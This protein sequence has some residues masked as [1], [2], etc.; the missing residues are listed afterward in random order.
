MLLQN[1]KIA[2]RV[3]TRHKGYALINLAGITVG[4][5][6]CLLIGLYIQHELSYDRYH[7]NHKNIYRLANK[8]DGASF[9]NGIAKIS[10]PWGPGLAKNFPEVESYCRFVF[11]GESL[12]KYG[13]KQSYEESGFYADSTVLK[14]FSWKLIKGDPKT[15]MEAPNNM[16]ISETF[17]KKYFGNE[18]P[19]GKTFTVGSDNDLYK[20]TGLIK[21]VPSNSHFRFDF[22]ATLSSYHHPDMDKWN[23]WNQFYT[24]LL[25]K[26]GVS[27]K[28]IEQKAHPFIDQHLDSAT[29]AVCTPFLQPLAGIHLH[30]D[31]FR[32]IEPN[33]NS[34]YVYIFG[35]LALF[36]ILIACLNFINLS[37]AQAIRRGTE[38]G[39]RKVNGASRISL[40][41]QFLVETILI[42]LVSI[43][44]AITLA[45]ITLPYLNNFLE[46]EIP[47]NWLAG[48]WILMGLL[49]LFVFV[50]LLSGLYPAAVLAS[51]NPAKIIGKRSSGMLS[52]NLLRKSLVVC[53][54]S[55]SI[56]M[57]IAAIV[58]GMQLNY[59][60]NKKLGFNKDQILIIQLRNQETIRRFETIKQELKQVPGVISV[61]ASANRPGGS[62]FGIPFEIE[63]IP[64][65]RLPAMRNLVVDHDFLE[66]YQMEIVSGRG[67]SKEMSTDTGTYLINEEAAR[68]LGLKNTVGTM[69]KMP[70]FNRAPA[71]I[72]GVV[73][74]FHFRSLH[75]KIAPL[76]LFIAPAWFSQV[77]VRINTTNT[78]ETIEGLS[79]KWAAI[80]PGNPFS[81]T[82]FDEG[83]NRLYISETRTAT[84]IRIFS[85]LA[86]FI[87]CL[88][89]L[90]LATHATQQ[91]IK[92]I[93]IRKVLGAKVSGIVYLL[94]IDFLKL[95]IIA[96][97][98]A[99]PIAWWA[100]NDWLKD[101]AYRVTIEWWVFAIAGMSAL[102]I[103][104]LTVGYK[105]ISAAIVNPV[106][107]LRTE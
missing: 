53:Q 44:L 37:T 52:G 71:P 58:T 28:A 18:D 40:M 72:I 57:I 3:L 59:I 86:I 69:M 11:F 39:I 70:A 30:S 23:R 75:E 31:L 48:K 67:F 32:E 84:I 4:V 105:A 85:T 22:L 25:L 66:T 107:S 68:Q 94:S 17:A 60:N 77:S 1:L 19:I 38:V 14:I 95:V 100:M 62:D 55:I 82:F 91:R 73:K 20:V 42:C 56:V 106:K 43:V 97:I 76:F 51:F 7:V 65:D 2:F 104:L 49:I 13:D 36:I 99:F 98:I 35:T 87:A 90:G 15:A 102:L 16:I 96:A 34:N 61:T 74:D 83:F 8:V 47:F 27:V 41:W 26:P 89:L 79:Q 50:S 29:A 5:T 45:S 93:G 24:Y 64:N 88:G 6:V 9:E 63:G 92:E 33:S 46:K 103:T 101:F 80:E 21:D 10:A 81:Y 12:F 54:F 78:E